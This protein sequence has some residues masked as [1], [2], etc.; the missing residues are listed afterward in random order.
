MMIYDIESPNKKLSLRLFSL[1]RVIGNRHI[2]VD[3][4]IVDLSC[5]IEM[6]LWFPELNSIGEKPKYSGHENYYLMGL[7][8]IF[9]SGLS[10]ESKIPYMMYFEDLRAVF[11]SYYTN[12]GLVIAAGKDEA[13]LGFYNA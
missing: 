6:N 1:L 10:N 13:V 8:V 3:R 2:K 4:F 9:K 12:A 11:P 5:Q 7:P